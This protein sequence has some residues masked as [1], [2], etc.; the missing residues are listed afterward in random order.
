[1]TFLKKNLLTKLITRGTH[2]PVAPFGIASL[3]TPMPR[4]GL[5]IP[6]PEFPVLCGVRVLNRPRIVLDRRDNEELFQPDFE[7]K[8]PAFDKFGGNGGIFYL[9]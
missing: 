6:P 2:E 7:R 8:S 3:I 9:V 1:V 5:G 4:L